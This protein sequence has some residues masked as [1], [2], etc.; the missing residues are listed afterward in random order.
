MRWGYDSGLLAGGRVMSHV[1]EGKGGGLW[2]SWSDMVGMGSGCG[3]RE[4]GREGEV[5]V[6][7]G[8]GV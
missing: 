7:M 2:K 3:G 1:G 8:R 6:Y 5:S 4:G